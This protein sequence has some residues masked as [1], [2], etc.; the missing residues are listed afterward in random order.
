MSKYIL[1]HGVF[2]D[3]NELYHYGVKGMK[4][5]VRKDEY[6][7]MTRKQRKKLQDDYFKTEAG[8][9]AIKRLNKNTTIGVLLGGPLGGVIAGFSTLKRIGE[10]VPPASTEKTVTAGKSVVSKNASKKVSELT[11]KN[12]TKT[13]SK[14]VASI[15][16]RVTG[17]KENGKPA[18]LMSE[19][20]LTDFRNSYQDRRNSMLK[21]YRNTSDPATKNNIAS[22]LDRM[23]NDYLN[24]VEQD[25]WYADDF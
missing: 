19:K 15:K 18:F 22:Q 4:W 14:V 5:G 1:M 23:E 21:Q 6:K 8:S 20:E 7:A 13:E 25:F 2:A 3:V 17:K 11:D 16:E 9:A 10:S 24:V 12:S